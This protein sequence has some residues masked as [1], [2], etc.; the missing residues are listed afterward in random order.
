MNNGSNVMNLNWLRDKKAVAGQE[1]LYGS[2]VYDK[3]DK[4]YIIKI[5]NT[6][7]E[8]KEIK[9]TLTGLKKGVVPTVG[10]CTMM[11]NADLKTINTLDSPIGIVP[12]ETTGSIEGRVFTTTSKP[13][14]FNVYRIKL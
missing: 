7:V 12:Q 1:N 6:S 2:A 3:V 9:I 14:S 13:Q 10:E 4:C 8:T 5:A 11:Q